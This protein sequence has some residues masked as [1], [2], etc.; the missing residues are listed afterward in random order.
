MPRFQI[1]S[2]S[3]ALILLGVPNR[4]NLVIVFG[5][6]QNW[7]VYATKDIFKISSYVDICYSH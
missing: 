4:H 7:R 2:R 6:E 1:F 5:A 3:A